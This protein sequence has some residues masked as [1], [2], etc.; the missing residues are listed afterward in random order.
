MAQ[1]LLMNIFFALKGSKLFI[2]NRF[3]FHVVQRWDFTELPFHDICSYDTFSKKA[4][5]IFIIVLIQNES[6]LESC[7]NWL[8][9][10]IS[11][12]CV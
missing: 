7:K 8:E 2:I 9:Y 12:I 1:L 3:L 6:K 4:R 10:L 5:F 11:S